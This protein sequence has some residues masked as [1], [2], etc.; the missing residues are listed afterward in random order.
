VGKKYEYLPWP[1]VHRNKPNCCVAQE[2][3]AI[4]DNIFVKRVSALMVQALE[5]LE[6]SLFMLW[7]CVAQGAKIN[8]VSVF[9]WASSE[10]PS[11]RVNC[12]CFSVAQRA[13]ASTVTTN[14]IFAS[15]FF[16]KKTSL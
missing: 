5:G 1:L 2:A 3:K 7:T 14:D 16:P 11:D 6:L 8:A 9:A 10:A 4:L 13:K 15:N 12:M